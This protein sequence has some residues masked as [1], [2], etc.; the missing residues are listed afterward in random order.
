MQASDEQVAETASRGLH[1]TRY[2]VEDSA[3]KL[4][5]QRC[6]KVVLNFESHLLSDHEIACLTHYIFNLS[7]S[8][9]Y[10]FARFFM[11]SQKRWFKRSDYI[12]YQRDCDI[13]DAIESLSKTYQYTTEE[14]DFEIN[15]GGPILLQEAFLLTFDSSNSISETLELLSLQDL[16][17]ISALFKSCSRSKQTI[18]NN[19]TKLSSSKNRNDLIKD[20]ILISTQSSVSSFFQP[21]SAKSSSLEGS[22]DAKTKIL[23]EANK[24]L[25]KDVVKLNPFVYQTMSRA[26]LI[27]F[28]GKDFETN[29]V[30]AALLSQMSVMNFPKYEIKRSQKYFTSRRELIDFE[31]AVNLRIEVDSLIATKSS[32]KRKKQADN[33]FKK[34]NSKVMDSLYAA[35]FYDDGISKSP[36]LAHPTPESITVKAI[37]LLCAGIVD[38]HVAEWKFLDT[39]LNQRLYHKS[40]RG[41]VY[42]RKAML[43]MNSLQKE[44]DFT[45]ELCEMRNKEQFKQHLIVEYYKQNP[46]SGVAKKRKGVRASASAPPVL[47]AK[48]EITDEL[49][50]E[51]L[52]SAMKLFWSR[53]ALQTC[54]RGLEDAAV[55]E[56]YHID[57][58]KRIT[59]LEKYLKIPMGSRHDF[60]H[61]VLKSAEHRTIQCDRIVDDTEEATIEYPNYNFRDVN[62]LAPVTTTVTKAN[63]FKRPTW[64]DVEGKREA[65]FVEEAALSFYRAQ[66]WEGMHSENSMLATLFA[67]LFWDIMWSTVRSPE[68][69]KVFTG[70]FEHH[71]Q[72]YPLDL[73]SKSFYMN[74]KRDIDGRLQKIRNDMDFV[75]KQIEDV[76]AQE[77]TRQTVSLGVT[78]YE[79]KALLAISEGL[80]TTALAIVCEILA[81][82]YRVM[83]SG[84]PDLCL[85][86]TSPSECMFSEVK[87]EFDVLSDK[88]CYWIDILVNSG[89][90]VEV[91]HVLEPKSFV[92]KVKL[93]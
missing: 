58:K 37:L 40:Q 49:S 14:S 88:Q 5:F 76:Y 27:Y 24:L 28:R 80:G 85:Y 15:E 10:L 65:V 56:V 48:K 21:S 86:K 74:R 34:L 78:W 54:I 77:A 47:G 32:D 70:I 79:L 39:F 35:T 33:L 71:C 30:E 72:S 90:R 57:L 4:F 2:P 11:R 55:H 82:D 42:I 13:K 67:F 64:V 20:L 18:P 51:L 91:C 87:S 41:K 25:G 69:G 61:F 9:K 44:F 93:A 3:Y 75:K 45:Q 83:K 50:D 6:L 16:K 17:T 12:Q 7:D 63:S 73:F 38:D 81:K 84:M 60:S 53:R 68:T 22:K 26:F 23:A 92:K 43:E 66:G 89:V 62:S 59:K 8:A 19:Q 52:T 1:Y 46:I 36:D 31:E 29:F